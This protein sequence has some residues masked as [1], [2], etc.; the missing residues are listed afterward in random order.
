MNIE[1]SQNRS[2]IGC[3]NLDMLRHSKSLPIAKPWAN[4]IYYWCNF[5]NLI[6]SKMIKN[7]I[8]LTFH[9]SMTR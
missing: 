7:F 6:I 9:G 8:K 1:S 4:E 3:V 5:D 2:I